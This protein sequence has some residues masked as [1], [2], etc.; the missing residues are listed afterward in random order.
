MPRFLRCAIP[1]S[2]RD[3][4][5]IARAKAK[6]ASTGRFVQLRRFDRHS[7][8]IDEESHKSLEPRDECE[9]QRAPQPWAKKAQAE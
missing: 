5:P 3:G 7:E 8:R 9:R 6:D 2:S 1:G 4:A